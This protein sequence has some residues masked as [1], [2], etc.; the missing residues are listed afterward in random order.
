M[1]QPSWHPEIPYMQQD[2]SAARQHRFVTLCDFAK[3]HIH[4][5]PLHIESPHFFQAEHLFQEL[6]VHI[7]AAAENSHLT[8]IRFH[9]TDLR[10]KL[11]QGAV[12]ALHEGVDAA[13]IGKKI[14]LPASFTS[15]PCFMQKN[16][17]NA[18]ALLRKFG[19]SDLFITFTANPHW[20]EVQEALLPHQAP[21]DRPDIIARVFNLKFES[22]LEDI[23]QKSI[24][25]KAV[26]HVYTVEYQKHGLPHIHLIVFLD[27]SSHIATPKAVDQVIS[28]ELPDHDNPRLFQLVK[29]FMIHGPCGFGLTSPCMDVHGKCTKQFPKSFRANTE[30]TGESYVQTR[31]QDTGR[32]M[33]IGDTFVNNQSVIS[34]SPYLLLKY[35]AHINVKCTAGFHA[36]K[37]IYKAHI[38][39]RIITPH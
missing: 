35:N 25:R 31:R 39:Q 18:L 2:D 24:F 10:A 14:V 13:S 20:R 38:L 5:C 32:F 28:T 22:M 21:H 23:M 17:E 11:Y 30:I 9:Q 3:F 15:G 34:Y 19:G 8:W 26:R 1:G 7:W 12:D 6:L 36:V 33:Q 37:Y 16:L 27:R 29:T 4:P